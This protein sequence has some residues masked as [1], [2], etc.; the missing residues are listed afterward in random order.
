MPSEQ[1]KKRKGNNINIY[2][3]GFYLNDTFE[4]DE[5]STHPLNI[6]RYFVNGHG[7]L[8]DVPGDLAR[9][10]AYFLKSSFKIF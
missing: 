5:V 6:H 3:V 8:N 7:D 1:L 2:S 9:S 4:I 10:C